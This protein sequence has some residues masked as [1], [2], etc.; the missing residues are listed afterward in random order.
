[1]LVSSFLCWKRR[2]TSSPS[3]DWGRGVI[4]SSTALMPQRSVCHNE[5]GDLFHNSFADVICSSEP[6]SGQL[7]DHSISHVHHPYSRESPR[8]LSHIVWD[9]SSRIDRLCMLPLLASWL[10]GALVPP[11]LHS[12]LS[13]SIPPSV[14]L[15]SLFLP[16]PP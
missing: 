4:P 2:N 16:I 13:P 3:Q 8:Q 11:S 15:S 5:S 7:Y 12:S 1:M 9:K 6:L 14:P 10:V